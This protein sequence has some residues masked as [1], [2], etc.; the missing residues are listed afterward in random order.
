[1]V[2]VKTAQSLCQ[3]SGARGS[4][5]AP[6]VGSLGVMVKICPA[7]APSPPTPLLGLT[8]ESVSARRRFFGAGL[9]AGSRTRE[10]DGTAQ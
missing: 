9:E 5:P 8:V 1:M 3:I 6:L 4:F 10:G 7:Q 2:P